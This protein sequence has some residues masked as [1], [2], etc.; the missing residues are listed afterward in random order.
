MLQ[1]MGDIFIDLK[2][3]SSTVGENIIALIKMQNKFW[4]VPFENCNFLNIA[5]AILDFSQLLPI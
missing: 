3:K 5:I 2:K 1:L 4:W